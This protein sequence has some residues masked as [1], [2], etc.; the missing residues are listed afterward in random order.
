MYSF[1]LFF[2]LHLPL[3]NYEFILYFSFPHVLI[4]LVH[5]NDKL[6]DS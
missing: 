1:F 3:S 6:V 2:F 5:G 4:H